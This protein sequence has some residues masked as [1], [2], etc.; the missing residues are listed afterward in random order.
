MQLYTNRSSFAKIM[1]HKHSIRDSTSVETKKYYRR[2]IPIVSFAIN[3]DVNEVTFLSIL[4]NL[5][6]DARL[7]IENPWKKL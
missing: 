3:M 2:K 4:V 7:M 6:L 5:K 1:L